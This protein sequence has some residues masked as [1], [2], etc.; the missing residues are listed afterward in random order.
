MKKE[1]FNKEDHSHKKPKKYHKAHRSQ[2]DYSTFRFYSCQKLGHIASNCPHAKVQIK[3]GNNKRYHAH[4][5][6]DNKSV[7]KKTR[8]DYSREEEY[9]LSHKFEGFTS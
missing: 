1:K 5:T 3:K 4:T 2:K 9:V 6:K 8:E 7:P